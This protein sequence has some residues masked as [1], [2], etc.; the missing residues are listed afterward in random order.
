MLISRR[1]LDRAKRARVRRRVKILAIVRLQGRRMLRQLA[2]ELAA[3]GQ[4][5]GVVL[6]FTRF[7]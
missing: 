7:K 5:P 1:A 2:Y 3:A 6:Q 4:K